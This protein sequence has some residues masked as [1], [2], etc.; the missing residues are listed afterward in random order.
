MA[1]F[2]TFNVVPDSWIS[3]YSLF[4]ALFLDFTFCFVLS[5]IQMFSAIRGQWKAATQSQEF[6]RTLQRY[7]NNAYMDAVKQDAINV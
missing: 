4:C 3:G 2:Y 6:F 1:Y 7:Y 5:S